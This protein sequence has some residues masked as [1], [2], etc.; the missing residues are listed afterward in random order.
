MGPLSTQFLC[1]I[2]QFLSPLL[3]PSTANNS[4][5]YT[6]PTERKF[7]WKMFA[8][9]SFPSFLSLS[10]SDFHTSFS[11]LSVGSFTVVK[12]LRHYIYIHTHIYNASRNVSWFILTSSLFSCVQKSEIF[13]LYVHCNNMFHLCLCLLQSRVH[14]LHLIKVW[15]WKEEFIPNDCEVLSWRWIPFPITF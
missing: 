9:N 2:D 10:G 14:L 1:F 5:S 7:K 4:S 8:L 13:P 15:P 6:C 12:M 3:I 11:V